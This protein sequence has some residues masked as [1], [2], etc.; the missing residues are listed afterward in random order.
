MPGDLTLELSRHY[1]VPFEDALQDIRGIELLQHFFSVGDRLALMAD[2]DEGRAFLLLVHA[3]FKQS[4]PARVEEA[5]SA[6][7]SGALR[8]AREAVVQCLG[9]FDA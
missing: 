2:C 1:D 4:L 9:L 5:F 6:H 8:P 3:R 7:V